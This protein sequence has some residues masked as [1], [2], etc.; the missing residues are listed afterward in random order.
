MAINDNGSPLWNTGYGHGD[1]LHVGDLI[2]SRPGLEVFKVD[3][4]TDQPAA[5]MADARTG[6]IDLA[7]RLLR[8]R[9]RPWRLRRRLGRQPRRRVV[10]GRRQRHLQHLGAN[11][12]RKPGSINF[13]AWW[14]ADPVRELLDGTHIDKYG[15]SARHPAADR[16]E[17]ALQQ[18]HQ[19]HPV[20]LR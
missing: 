7:Q 20:A 1:A 11:V 12:G 4:H 18:R 5:W 17:R 10:V 16:S 9:Q 14:D 8:L 19:V 2:P 15:T 3:E 13:L 6:A